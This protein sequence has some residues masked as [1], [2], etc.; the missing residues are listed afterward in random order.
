M[1]VIAKKHVFMQSFASQ[2]HTEI[3]A[4]SDLAETAGKNY[5]KILALLT[6]CAKGLVNLQHGI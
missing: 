3:I 5:F 2:L 4:A 6:T 1:V